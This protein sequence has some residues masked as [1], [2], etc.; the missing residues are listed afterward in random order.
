VTLR[1]VSETDLPLLRKLSQDP[2]TAGEFEWYGWY[3]PRL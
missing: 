2:Q 1:P 3:A